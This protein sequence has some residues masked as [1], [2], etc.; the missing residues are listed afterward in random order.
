M[1]WESGV[2]FEKLVVA[3]PPRSPTTRVCSWPHEPSPHY[4]DS[5]YHP[6]EYYPPT[7]TSTSQVVSSLEIFWR[8]F[9][10]SL[11]QPTRATYAVWSKVSGHP[12]ETVI[13]LS[14]W[15][16]SQSWT[17]MPGTHPFPLWQLE[18]NRGDF[19]PGVWTSLGEWQPILP[20]E[21]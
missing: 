19:L 10:C 8:T 3:F 12:L 1:T 14:L 16:T 20:A 21:P 2:V 6:F 5:F 7:Y 4:H 9:F 13:W 18:L 17:F 15:H 11:H